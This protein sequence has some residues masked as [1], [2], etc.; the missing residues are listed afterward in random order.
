[1]DESGINNNEARPRGYAFKGHR[2]FST[3]PGHRTERISIIGALNQNKLLAPFVFNGTCT[4]RV[5]EAWLEKI[6]LPNLPSGKVIVMDNAP[7]HNSQ[8]IKALIENA[9][10]KL[11]FLPPYSPDLNPIEHWWA[12]IKNAIRSALQ[13][14]D[15]NLTIATDFAFE[16][17]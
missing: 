6:L 8:K 9:G 17:L 15:H 7:F 10:H 3:R 16:I 2:L 5:I 13:V 14:F 4:A 11:L 1:M 12:K